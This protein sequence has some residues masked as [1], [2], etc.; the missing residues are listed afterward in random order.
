MIK[1]FQLK[2]GHFFITL[3]DSY[4]SLLFYLAFFDAIVPEEGDGHYLISARWSQKSGFHSIH[5]VT[6]DW[7]L[8]EDSIDPTSRGRKG[9]PP[10]IMSAVTL[11]R[12]KGGFSSQT[13]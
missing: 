7:T 8:H 5:L 10:C 6:A 2:T 3:Q 1:D 13:G 11:V 9:I 12:M 4:L